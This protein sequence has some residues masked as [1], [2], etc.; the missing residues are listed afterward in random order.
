MLREG[1]KYKP[2]TVPT[3]ARMALCKCNYHNYYYYEYYYYYYKYLE[4]RREEAYDLVKNGN[5]CKF[6]D[7]A[8]LIWCTEYS[9]YMY[10]HSVT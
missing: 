3:A 6:C 2:K 10:A 5:F 8:Q 7:T 9:R 4:K 1:N